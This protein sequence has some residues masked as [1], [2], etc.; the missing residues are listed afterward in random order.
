M[1]H[2][3]TQIGVSAAGTVPAAASLCTRRRRGNRPATPLPRRRFAAQPDAQRRL[4]SMMSPQIFGCD[5]IKKAVACLLFGGSR[6]R[7]P[8]GATLRGEWRCGGG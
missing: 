6:K 5:D 2:V 1:D 4:F 7:L 3:G 8:D